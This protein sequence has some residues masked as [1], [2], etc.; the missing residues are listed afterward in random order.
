VNLDS[1]FYDTYDVT[2]ANGSITSNAGFFFDGAKGGAGNFAEWKTNLFV[3][4]TRDDWSANYTLRYVGEVEENWYIADNGTQITRM[5]DSQLVQDARYTYF[6]ENVTASVGLN[7]IFDVDPPFAQG[8]FSDNTDPRT[9]STR[10]R[11]AFVSL[12]VVF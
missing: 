2:Q 6:F 5:I 7:N 9:Y 3:T 12:K 10:G 11:H 8:G 1:T 4:Y